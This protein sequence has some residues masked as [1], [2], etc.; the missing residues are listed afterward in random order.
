MVAALIHLAPEQKKR[1]ASR[2]RRR[3]TS[4]SKEVRDAV[5]LYLELPVE[6]E[7]DLSALAAAARHAT[8]QMI[9]QLDDTLAAV[10]RIQRRWK[11]QP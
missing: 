3:G 6:S 1:L 4:F 7:E 2:A 11:S 5:D 8:E 9:K 10:R